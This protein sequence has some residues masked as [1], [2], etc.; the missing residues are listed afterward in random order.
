MRVSKSKREPILPDQFKF[1]DIENIKTK[2]L[3]LKKVNDKKVVK[4]LK[5]C[6]REVKEFKDV[7]KQILSTVPPVAKTEELPYVSLSVGENKHLNSNFSKQNQKI[8]KIMETRTE[9]I[10]KKM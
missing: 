7:E 4:I 10:I 5:A 6:R 3:K 8:E 2:R 1:I 9:K